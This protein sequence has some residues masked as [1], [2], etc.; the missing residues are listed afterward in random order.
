MISRNLCCQISTLLQKLSLLQTC[1]HPKIAKS[2]QLNPLII[3]LNFAVRF[4]N[5]ENSTSRGRGRGELWNSNL[6]SKSQC[7]FQIFKKC[8]LHI[9]ATQRLRIHFYL[10]YI[11]FI[12]KNIFANG[13]APSESCSTIKWKGPRYE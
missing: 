10:L 8:I 11:V 12:V 1:V 7:G 6:C 2:I 4:A 5:C 13:S 3:S 9:S